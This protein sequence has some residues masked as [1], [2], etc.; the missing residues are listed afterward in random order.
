METNPKD[1]EH[2]AEQ[3]PAAPPEANPEPPQPPD[4]PNPEPWDFNNRRNGNVAHLPLAARDQLGYMMLDRVPY[5]EIPKRLGE[6]AKDITEDH[7]HNW[8][9]CGGFAEWAR[10]KQR[11]QALHATHETAHELAGQKAGNDIQ[12]SGRA[13]ASG[14]IHELLATFNPTA[15]AKA[16]IAKPDLYLKTINALSRLSEGEAVCAH[17]QVQKLLAEAKLK[18]HNDPATKKSFTLDELKDLARLLKLM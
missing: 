3:P 8:K 10:D 16:L 13:I 9:R 4:P 15:F 17:F 14:Q 6:V 5:A 7:I 18:T 1:P 2:Q 12:E 11:A